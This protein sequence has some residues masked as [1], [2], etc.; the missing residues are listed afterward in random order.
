MALVLAVQRG[1]PYLLGRS[2][3]MRTDHRS[4]KYLWDQCIATEAQ[5]WWLMK[6][7]GYDFIT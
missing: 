7:T 5:Q 1:Q 4:L 3:I 2:F 6:L